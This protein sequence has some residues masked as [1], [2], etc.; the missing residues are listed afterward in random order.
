MRVRARSIDAKTF[1][2][3]RACSAP[4]PSRRSGFY[5]IP[6]G[7]L[8][9]FRFVGAGDLKAS[10]EHDWKPAVSV[11]AGLEYDRAGNADPPARRWGLFFQYYTG[12]SPYGQFFRENVRHLGVG[13]LL[14]GL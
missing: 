8:G 2:P 11:R 5:L 10:G 3:V 6:L 12:P 13:V 4:S 1:N 7:S 9:G 14:G